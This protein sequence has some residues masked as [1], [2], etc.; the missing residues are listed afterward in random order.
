MNNNISTDWDID[1]DYCIFC[2]QK[3]VAFA[4]GNPRLEHYADQVCIGCAEL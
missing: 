4:S 1:M 3:F 2:K